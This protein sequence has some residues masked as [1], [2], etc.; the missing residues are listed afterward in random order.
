MSEFSQ[1]PCGRDWCSY[2]RH[3][4]NAKKQN[5]RYGF[6]RDSVTGA[7]GLFVESKSRYWRKFPALMR[8]NGTMKHETTTIV[9]K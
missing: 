4:E 8:S 5:R 2:R 1:Y 7:I 9:W 3:I 6:G